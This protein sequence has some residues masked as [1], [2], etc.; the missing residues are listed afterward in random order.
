MHA[1]ASTKH[2]MGAGLP[3]RLLLLVAALLATALLAAVPAAVS[4]AAGL[5]ATPCTSAGG[6]ATCN[7]WSKPGTLTLPGGATVNVWAYASSAGSAASVPGPVLIVNQGDVVTVNLTNNLA[8]PSSLLF[9]GQQMVPDTAGVAPGGSK[10]YSFTASNPGTFLYEAGLSAGEPRQVAMGLYGTLVVRPASAGQAYADPSTAY[11]DEAQV[12]LGEIDPALNANPTTFDIRNFAPKYFLVNGKAF[13]QTEA[14][15][16]SAGNKVLLRF[17][18]AGLMPHSMSVLGLHQVLVATDGSPF[19]MSRGLVAETLG[20]GQTADAIV[21]VPGGA[22]AGS[23]FALYDANLMLRN[24]SAAG[25][26]GMLAFLTVGT[27]TPPGNDTTGPATTS[28][29]LAPNPTNGSIAVTVSASVSDAAS[30]G[31]NV[32]AAEYRID[33]QGAAAMA[34]VAGDGAFN[35]AAEAVTA[36]LSPATLAGLASGNHTIYIRGQDAAGNWG[37]FNFATL[38]LDKTGPATK[39]L[40]LAPNPSNGTGS[41]TLSGTADDS[42]S[43]GSSIASAQYKIDGGAAS[44]MTLNTSSAPVASL[45]ATIDATTLSAGTHTVSVQSTDALGNVGA[46]ATISLIVDKTGPATSGVAAAPNPNNGTLGIN[47]STPAVRVTATL[48]DTASAIAGGE[49]FIDTLG[50]DGAGFPFAAS[51]GSFNSQ[52]EAATADVPLTTINALSQ[53]NHTVY[54]HGRDAAG[55]WGPTATTVLLVDKTAP[56]FT[57]ISLS[58]N[59]TAGA[60]NVTLTINGAA[61]NAGGAGVAGG[62]YWI[63]PPTSTNP[64]PGGGTQFTGSTATIPVGSL[65]LGSYTVSAR[66]RD[67][68]GNWSTGSSGIRTATLAVSPPDVIFSDGFESGNFSAWSSRSTTNTSRL[69]VTTTAKLVGA[70]GLQSQGNN[71]NYVQYNWGTATNPASATYD[72]R[73]YFRPNGNSSTGKDILS[74]ATSNTFGTTLFRVRYRLS[75]TTPQVQI[76]A[77]TSN[78]NSTWTNL[79]GGTSNNFLE[80]VWQA[81]GSGG[82]NPG[83]LRLYVNGVQAQTLTMTSTGAVGAVRMGSV[84]N[85]GTNTLMYFDAFTSKRSVSPLAG[86]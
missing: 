82:P 5:P 48:A 33:S 86:P 10:T 36:S 62:E 38:N 67:A 7:L 1:L 50:A 64:A 75:G 53:G 41:A 23:K 35:S 24:S 54:V 68:A 60:T 19:S 32:T 56:T 29:G 18:N 15:A 28:T 2:G 66:I 45:T 26:G 72:A 63:N 30:G 11:T 74:A 17:V 58:P 20:P 22:T 51:D 55:N 27:A 42:A 73:M 12:V 46:P 49:G 80:V 65:A 14:I 76:Q 79:L 39:G 77:G 40:T 57:G 61:D 21:T 13:P 8:E 9:K 37:P 47:S 59:P 43:G 84:T 78:T 69:N 83:T 81:V 25:F 34:M 16:T 31:S 70:Y 3:A 71:T 6:A 85:T 44:A 4:E 52:T